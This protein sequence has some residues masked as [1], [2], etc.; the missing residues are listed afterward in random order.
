M[1]A[2]VH[3]WRL[4]IFS[5]HSRAR[6]KRTSRITAASTATFKNGDDVAILLPEEPGFVAYMAV[7]IERGGDELRIRPVKAKA[8]VGE[9]GPRESIDMPDRPGLY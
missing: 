9:G 4:N 1:S 2:R 8:P 6:R 5:D 7:T 3:S